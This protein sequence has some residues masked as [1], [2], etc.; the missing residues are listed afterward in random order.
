VDVAWPQHRSRVSSMHERTWFFN[1]HLVFFSSLNECL[2][3]DPSAEELM[4]HTAT[5]HSHRRKIQVYTRAILDFNF[6]AA[7]LNCEACNVTLMFENTGTVATEW[8]DNFLYVLCL[9]CEYNSN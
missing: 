4:Y 5:R 3:A 7:P 6:S 1:I 9:S 2:D 8:Y